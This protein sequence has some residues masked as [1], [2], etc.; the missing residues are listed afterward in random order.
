MQH[1]VEKYLSRVRKGTCSVLAHGTQTRCEPHFLGPY[2]KT[3]TMPRPPNLYGSSDL[4][5]IELVTVV[6]TAQTCW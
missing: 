1:L 4:H 5:V 6:G 2:H 3:Y